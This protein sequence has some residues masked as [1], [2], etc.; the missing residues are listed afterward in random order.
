[1]IS[2]SD[3]LNFR[4]LMD[5][6]RG[7]PMGRVS[8]WKRNWAREITRWSASHGGGRQN[9]KRRGPLMEPT[10]AQDWRGEREGR[11]LGLRW[12]GERGMEPD[13]K[14]ALEE[15]PEVLREQNWGELIAGAKEEWTQS[16]VRLAAEGVVRGTACRFRT[17]F[18]NTGWRKGRRSL[19]RR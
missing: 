4:S 19:R 1:M 6:Q 12:R 16:L 2:V 15:L 9:G 8:D 13:Q 3:T 11:T 7:S 14:R 5:S 18:A 17:P 10:G